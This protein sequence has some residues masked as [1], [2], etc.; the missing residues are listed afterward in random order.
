MSPASPY[1]RSLFYDDDGGAREL[2]DEAV[3]HLL[4]GFRMKGSSAT[5][6][7]GTVS[8]ASQARLEAQQ[9][10]ASVRAFDAGHLEILS[11]PEVIARVNQLLADRFR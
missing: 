11:R 3:F 10:A 7:D 8:V 5:A 9:Q 1:L 4:L 2:P 6:N